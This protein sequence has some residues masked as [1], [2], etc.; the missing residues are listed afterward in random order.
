MASRRSLPVRLDPFEMYLFSRGEH[1][2]LHRLL[3]AQLGHAPAAA[4]EA[5][6]PGCRFALWAPGVKAVSVVGDFND[7]TPGEHPLHLIEHSGVW[8]GYVPGVT[9][10]A[11]YKFA[12]RP[13][14]ADLIFKPD[15]FA[16]HDE[17][18]PDAPSLV[19]T[20]DGYQWGDA[21]WMAR[22]PGD[23]PVH[24]RPLAV[25]SLHLG[26]WRRGLD[27]RPLSYGE[28]AER[29]PAYVAALG[30]THV[31]FPPL[32]DDDQ[33]RTGR[34]FA[35]PADLGSPEE[36]RRL[37]D[38][39]HQAGL[40]V[41]LDWSAP[42]CPREEWDLE[43]ARQTDAALRVRGRGET[44]NIL[45][46]SALY[47][48]QEFHVDGLKLAAGPSCPERFEAGSGGE[49]EPLEAMRFLQKLNAVVQGRFPGGFLIA[50]DSLAW[51]GETR[52]AHLGG[53]GFAYAWDGAWTRDVLDYFA[54]PPAQRGSHQADLFFS[55]RHAFAERHVLPLGP[56]AVA[57]AGL[58]SQMPGEDGERF[59]NLRALY[60]YMWARPGKKLLFMGGEFGQWTAWRPDAALDWALLDFPA[61]R[62]LMRLIADLNGLHRNEP[63]LHELDHDRRG[64]AWADFSDQAAAVISFL[65]L[66]K[67]GRQVLWACNF[68]SSVL[69]DYGV[70]CRVPGLWREIFN[71]DAKAYGGSNLG[72]AGAVLAVPRE[73]GGQWPHQLPL[74][75]PPL[76]VVAL[77]PEA[78]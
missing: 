24:E 2:E 64:F 70:P 75:L 31:E 1:W 76:S 19:W 72:N 33:G 57:R 41:I 71:S 59:A 73:A 56:T 61:H 20:L 66:D 51:A 60:S 13:Q 53:L 45:L 34:L 48:F 68:G 42:L 54:R 43:R 36:L 11:R 8:A 28:L 21:A 62:G 23:E 52:P 38:R 78:A 15:P 35:P 55:L 16:F 4:E 77:R 17:G 5:D 26:S 47:W 65:R 46:A 32:I 7:W 18:R 67:Q 6:L 14:N 39:C 9:Q 74:T 44:D 58:L 12:I 10:G 40:G 49:E 29:L 63:A 50:D 22:R 30:F 69:R 3:G 37:I 25:Y 27:G